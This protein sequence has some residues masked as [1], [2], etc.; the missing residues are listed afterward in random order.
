[1]TRGHNRPPFP[2]KAPGTD[3]RS[4]DVPTVVIYR[5]ARSVMS[6]EMPGATR[7]QETTENSR[8]RRNEH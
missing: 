1:M 6:V 3:M 7:F 5:P 4:W 2:P 8:R